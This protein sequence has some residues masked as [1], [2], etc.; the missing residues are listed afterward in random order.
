MTD[1]YPHI[2]VATV[3][4]RD[5]KY[6]MVQEHTDNGEAFNQPAGHLEIGEN[7]LQ[8]AVRETL[9]ETG[10]Q[11]E[12]S[13]VLGISQYRSPA[14]N[15]T[16]IRVSFSARAIV[17][18]PDAKLDTG[19]IAAHWMT[20]TQIEQ[21]PNLRSPMILADIDTFC[22]QTVYPLSMIRDLNNNSVTDA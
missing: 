3:V 9:E 21:L 16:Y 2:T 4:H 11:V 5:G 20:R 17:Q 7:L 1:N 15:I 10:W 6:L 18:V 12:L 13:G 22:D 14:N 8:A 19:I